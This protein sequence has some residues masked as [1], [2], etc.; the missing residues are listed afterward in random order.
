M[1]LPMLRFVP[2]P[3]PPQQKEKRPS[4]PPLHLPP[5]HLK[6]KRL[7][8]QEAAVAWKWMLAQKLTY[9]S[10]PAPTLFGLW[11][12]RATRWRGRALVLLLLAWICCSTGLS[13]TSLKVRLRDKGQQQ[14][15]FAL[16]NVEFRLS[17]TFSKVILCEF[18]D[19]FHTCPC[20]RTTTCCLVT[21]QPV[22]WHHINPW[23][24]TS[25]GTCWEKYSV[26]P[27]T[28]FWSISRSTTWPSNTWRTWSKRKGEC[29]CVCCCVWQFQ[30]TRR[31]ERVCSSEETK[32]LKH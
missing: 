11:N 22:V 20:R 13:A 21:V 6:M 5:V 14:I 31:E 7:L 25:G 23:K 2:Q 8:D 15:P 17:W 12:A 10:P 32:N 1:K 30:K 26:S 4:P 9:C 16:I 3:V 28:S 24:N 18:S 27:V 19:F 29:W